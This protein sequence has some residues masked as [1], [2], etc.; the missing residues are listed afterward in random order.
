M[1]PDHDVRPVALLGAGAW[2]LNWART[3]HGVGALGMVCDPS[4]AA[5]AEVRRRYPGLPTTAQASDVL[6]NP[7]LTHVVVAAPAAAHFELALAAL[8]ARKHV[9]VEKPLCLRVEDGELLVRLAESLGRTLMVGHLL[10]YH[11]CIARVRE[12][13]QS[14]A[15]GKLLTITSNRLNLGRFR[16]E[17]DALWSFAPHDIS[18]ILSL[19]GDQMPESL[20]CVGSA[21]LRREVVDSTLTVMR[22]AGDVT[23]Q[24]HV[25]WLN[26]FKEQKLTIV[27][28]DGMLVF[29]DTKPWSEK[30]TL[31][32]DYLSWPE[33]EAPTPRDVVGEHVSVPEAEPLRAECEHFLAVSQA[34]STPRTDGREGLRVLR[35]L[36]LAR[37]SLEQGGE[38]VA[39]TEREYFAH[40]TAVVEPGADIGEGTKIWHF[41]HVMK[42][43]RIGPGCSLG[44]S[45]HVAGGAVLGKSV[46]VQN[47]VSVYAGAIIE[48]DVFLGPSCVL[49]NVKNPRSQLDRRGMYE[50][51]LIR[52]GASV[53]ANATIVCGVTLGRYAFIA[54]GAVVTRDVPDYALVMG[55]PARQVGWMSRHGHRMQ[56]DASGVMTCAESGLRYREVAPGVLCC[57]DWD[58]D[59]PLPAELSRAEKRYDELKG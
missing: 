10:Q 2:G 7:A 1:S 9:L 15:L 40:P 37:R 41:A 39:P 52:R 26:P 33:G 48:D 55:N 5:L 24:I 44:Q 45:A 58:E 57:L 8:R 35:V 50:R 49:T 51:T 42:G 53:G 18:V 59:A 6:G 4:P 25:S 56:P 22:F 17:E 30:L 19:L 34:G 21:S 38:A 13:V 32:R 23:A 47:N 28:R 14:G 27:G 31:Y 12:L 29:D 36:A 46:K 11:P 43:A 20:R 54:A 16:K 3:L